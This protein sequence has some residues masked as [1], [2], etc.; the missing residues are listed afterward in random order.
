MKMKQGLGNHW[1]TFLERSRDIILVQKKCAIWGW[2][3]GIV[4][5]NSVVNIE[6]GLGSYTQKSKP[7]TG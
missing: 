2:D 5:W 3:L 1:G 7:G 6:Q 4:H